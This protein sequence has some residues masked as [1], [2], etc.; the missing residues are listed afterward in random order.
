MSRLKRARG[1]VLLVVVVL[2]MALVGVVILAISTVR[3]TFPQTTGELKIEGLTSSVQ[4]IRDDRGVPTIYADNAADLFRAQGFVTAQDRFFEM[5]LRRHIT[6]GRLSELVGSSGI[7]KDRV[8]RTMGWRRVAEAELPKL[9]PETRQYLQAYADGVN[10]YIS[11]AGS[12]EKMSL[13]YTFLSRTNP[14]YRVEPWTPVDSLA[15]LK[16]MA[17]DLRGDYNDELARARLSRRT[18]SIKQIKLL[19]PPYPYERNLPILSADDWKPSASADSSQAASAV[20]AA[21]RTADG[22]AALDAAARAVDAVPSELGAGRDIGSNSWVVSGSRTTTGKPLLANDPHLSLSIPGIW[23]QV[24]L[25]CRTVSADCPFRVSGF[26]FSGL[27]GVVIGH[28]DSIAWGF[29]N[30]NPDV[31][32]FY[33]EQVTGDTYLRDGVQVPVR[34]RTETIKVAGGS[35]VTFTVR[36]TVHGPILSDAVPGVDEA[37][38]RVVVR[39]A[40]QTNRYAVSL[41]WTALTPSTTGDAIFALDRARNWKE[42]RAAAELFAV[43]SQNLVYADT[44]G[45]IG[46]QAPGRIPIRRSATPDE[47]PGFW[48]APGWDS[49]WD[50]KGY[51]PFDDLP[52]TYDPSEGYI[53][54]ANQAVTASP[55]PFLTTEWDYGFRAQRIRTLLA[56]TPKVSPQVMSQIQ[57]DVRNTYAP[58]LVERLL[59]VQ[60]DDFTAQAQR[61]LRDWDGSQPG[62]KSRD[63]AAAAYYNAVWKH[64]L[65]Y[66]FDELPP[67]MAPDG[68]SRWMIVIEQLLKDPKNDWWDDK[69]TP[70]VTEGS[71]EILKRALVDARLDLARKLGKVPATWRWGRLHQLDLKHPVMGDPSVPEVVRSLF[72]RGGIELGGGNAIVNANSWKAS[73]PGY[74]VTSGP[75]MRMVVDLSDL[76]RSLWVNSTG[77]SGHAYDPHYT[78]QIDAWVANEPFPWPF[79]DQ[80]V[81]EAS[82]DELTLDPVTPTGPSGSLSPT[83]PGQ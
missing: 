17:W 56:S 70:G 40:Q 32:D 75:S 77:Q 41:A 47:P 15:W 79:T 60:V 61:L 71:G 63:A 42:F 12:P 20:P 26:T 8:I 66:T 50:W 28:N 19:Y 23:T 2:L 33:L 49:Q 7:D 62:D 34:K 72:D 81:K 73:D 58:T 21:F 35:D 52:H 36:S 37:G 67:D 38:D 43:P 18:T 27:P 78:D 3:Q 57:G 39:G 59:A 14:D 44:E 13:E 29:T 10:A 80:A 65:E 83:S 54:T 16:A 6:A 64:L 68:G 25:Q 82:A 51:V 22:A 76:D 31:T 9:A 30:L 53:V 1:A 5:D 48:P 69:T 4:V 46:Y 11:R 55:T 24:N 74:D 45:H